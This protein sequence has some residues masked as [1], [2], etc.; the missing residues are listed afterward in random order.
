MRHRHDFCPITTFT[1]TPAQ[2]CAFAQ[3]CSRALLQPHHVR[4]PP[5]SQLPVD[6]TPELL[7]HGSFTS[8][9]SSSRSRKR[10]LV[11]DLFRGCTPHPVSTAV[12]T[13]PGATPSSCVSPSQAIPLTNP[14]Q[15]FLE[16]ALRALTPEEQASIRRHVAADTRNVCAAVDDAYQ[17]AVR[18]K[19]ICED[20][21]W[22]W[23][24][25]GQDIALR[26]EAEKVLL[27]LERFKSIG[28]VVAN[29]DPLHA[30]LP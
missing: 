15:R 7:G 18:H 8:I 4:C 22:Y 29:V 5:K 12:P 26:D 30:G 20:K 9:M 11:R 6:I 21:R 23:T 3:P 14:S 19:Q 28:D 17:A 24:F 27:W 13:S 1:E 10:D 2:C 25:R 16:V